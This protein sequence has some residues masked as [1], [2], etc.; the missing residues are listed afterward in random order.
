MFFLGCFPEKKLY[1]F[2][3]IQCVRFD[4]YLLYKNGLCLLTHGSSIVLLLLIELVL[5]LKVC[6][7]RF[8]A[9][10]SHSVVESTMFTAPSK[11]TSLSLT[12]LKAL[13]SRRR[14]TRFDG[15]PRKTQHNSFCPQMVCKTIN[16]YQSD[17]PS[18]SL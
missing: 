12:T 8:R 11:V 2:R 13:K 16:S 3:N 9:R 15:C 4:F 6:V 5:I 7:S 14:L 1:I 10:T 18:L 17:S